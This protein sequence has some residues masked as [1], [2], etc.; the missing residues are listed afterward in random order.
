MQ[1]PDESLRNQIALGWTMML[2]VLAFVFE[3]M[4][5]ESI[6]MDNNFATLRLDPGESTKWLV[7]LVAL[8]A[9]MPV[10]VHLVHGMSTRLFR[11]GAVALA[12]LGFLFFLLHHLSHWQF[13]QRP[14]LS[15]HVL[16]LV[17]HLIGL[18]V[19]VNSVRWARI[20]RPGVA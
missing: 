6:L 3:F 9:L 20:P 8:Y 10:Y 5:I 19:V 2:L 4:T 1:S 11:W 16:D 7:Y 15:S 14:D 13:G 17:L 12:S 18:W